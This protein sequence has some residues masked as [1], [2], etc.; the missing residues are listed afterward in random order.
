MKLNKRILL[1]SAC[2][3]VVLGVVAVHYSHG[4]S[5]VPVRPLQPASRPVVRPYTPAA[6]TQQSQKVTPGAVSRS[7]IDW[8][9]EFQSSTD[10]FAS[11]SK[12]SKAALDGDGRAAYYVAQ[13]LMGCLSM[14]PRKDSNMSPEEWFKMLVAS[15]P[16]ISP[17]QVERERKQ[18]EVCAGFY[19][20]NDV[21]ADLPKREGGYKSTKYWMDLAYQDG[22]PIAETSHA[23]LAIAN[24]IAAT[25]DSINVAQADIN[26]AIASGDPEAIFLAGM[27]ITDGHYVERI[28]GFAFSL[29]ACDLGYDCSATN[30]TSVI[31][32]NCA[33]EGNCPAGAVFS[34]WVTKNIGAEGYAQ[35][36][37]RAQQ[38]ETAL[39]QGDTSALQQ[40]AQLKH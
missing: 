20:G 4:P 29:A 16:F 38:I 37:A 36:Y 27:I 21:F 15:R 3:M 39:A 35:A 13:K 9:K 5:T 17:Q 1:G 31:F 32:Q 25:P 40:F 30:T 11:I 2:A 7:A 14:I 18:F 23:A 26:H 12:A 19:K 22:D 10:Y 28:Q 34:D 6:P 8:N 24:P 33:T